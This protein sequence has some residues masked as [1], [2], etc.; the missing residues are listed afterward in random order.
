MRTRL[1]FTYFSCKI[2][3]MILYFAVYFCFFTMTAFHLCVCFVPVSLMTKTAPAFLTLYN[4]GDHQSGAGVV[5]SQTSTEKVLFD[6][7]GKQVPGPNTNSIR[8]IQKEELE[9]GVFYHL[10]SGSD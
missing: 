5:A 7:E 3:E 1:F 8:I 10:N 2:L 6:L 4:V 9:F